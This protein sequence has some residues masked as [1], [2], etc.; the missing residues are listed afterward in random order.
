MIFGIFSRNLAGFEGLLSG[1]PTEKIQ[2]L[3]S[4]ETLE[5]ELLLTG[6]SPLLSGELTDPVKMQSVTFSFV[7]QGYL[8]TLTDGWSSQTRRKII[9]PFSI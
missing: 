1:G 9:R 4:K 8:A 2:R 7:L 6:T 5:M 3:E